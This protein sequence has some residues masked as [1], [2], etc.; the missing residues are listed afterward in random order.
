MGIT[1]YWEAR[2]NKPL[3]F[4]RS[5]TSRQ[6]VCFLCGGLTR[7]L[8]RSW[9]LHRPTPRSSQRL[10]PLS[11]NCL[12]AFPVR[13]VRFQSLPAKAA[14]VHRRTNLYDLP[15]ADAPDHRSYHLYRRISAKQA[16]IAIG[17]PSAET[18]RRLTS[19]RHNYHAGLL[20]ST[21][22]LPS[23]AIP[24]RVPSAKSVYSTS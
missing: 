12:P 21:P 7:S 1:N 15:N 16:A 24:I 23:T 19:L 2:S 3:C 10:A 22:P 8:H 20:P 17:V 6:S 11:V 13:H 4:T 9:R 14:R 5:Y 18:S